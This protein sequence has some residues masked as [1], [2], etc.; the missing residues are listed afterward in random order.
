MLPILFLLAAAHGAQEQTVA[1]LLVVNARIYVTARAKPV[2]TMAI[3]DGRIAAIGEDALRLAGPATRRLDLGGAPVF[4]SFIDSHA[5]MRSLGAVLESR[6]LRHVRTIADIAAWVRERAATLPKGSWIVARN[7]D[8]T[9]W[10]GAFPD[11]KDLD[12][13]A[14]DHPVFLSRVDGHA[15][16]VN[17]IALRLAGIEEKTPD[18]PGGRILRD[19]AG[20]PTGVLIDQAMGLVRRRIP[21][22]SFA[23]IKR[24]LALAAAECA[25][26]GLAGVH[27]AGVTQ[28][29]LRAYRELIS[30]GRLPIRIYA[31]IGGDGPLWREYL[32]RGPEIGE[33][34]TVRAIK[35][36]ADGALGSRGA[37]LWQ[38]YADD[39]NNTGLLIMPKDEI[40]RIARQAAARGFQV[41][42]HAIGDRANRIV[43]DAY[44]AV[45]GGP[46]DRRF[47]IEHAQV[48]SLPDFRLFREF[49]IIAAIQATHATSDMRWAEARLGPDRIAGAYAWRR[50]LA[51]GIPLPNGS[52][53]PVEEPDPMAGFYA[54]IT[55][56][57]AAGSPPGGW[58]PEQKM[59]REEA[60]E[61]WTIFPA[62]AA[63]EEKLRGTLDPG[64]YADFIVLDRDIMTIPPAEILRTRVKMH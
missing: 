6:D 60:L 23:E 4:P 17:T 48:V 53:F 42:T 8:Q 27:D 47:R 38:P 50:F 14:P 5:H 19:A 43:L 12:S 22:P 25:R 10:G 1:D 63:F 41:C 55:R 7:W 52:D 45:L 21:P 9:H 24:Q 62:F 16:W 33:W 2:S 57:D 34:L 3:R 26:L 58:T 31:M 56:Q 59:T 39:R 13:A 36:F 51:L 30:E 11:A 15:A 61:S 64:K 20:R 40:E 29:D 44:A 46:N 28:E 49:S 18:P 35:L 37:A 32:N 54:S